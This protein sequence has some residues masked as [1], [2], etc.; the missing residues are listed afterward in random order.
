MR[1]ET[2]VVGDWSHDGH[3]MTDL[4]HITV[5]SHF[6]EIDTL[7]REAL[8]NL[9]EFESH[10]EKYEAAEVSLEKF[11]RIR[12]A[13]GGAFQSKSLVEALENCLEDSD[14]EVYFDP[15]MYAHLW[16][17]YVNFA[18]AKQGLLGKVKFVDKQ[19]TKIHE[20]GGY[21]LFS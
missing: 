6:P 8:D 18:A 9:P 12:D 7:Y 10:F 16:V 15:E 17:E 3:C 11:I 1:E 2:I 19:Q 13:L 5:P 21:G 4:F 14:D 20:I